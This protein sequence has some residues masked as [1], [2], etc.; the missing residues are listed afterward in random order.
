MMDPLHWQESTLGYDYETERITDNLINI[1][2][3]KYDKPYKIFQVNTDTEHIKEL[4][5]T[6][7][8]KALAY[9]EKYFLEDNVLDLAMAINTEG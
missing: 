3:L 4:R 5:E 7:D 6:A 2:L 9:D 8:Y 1:T